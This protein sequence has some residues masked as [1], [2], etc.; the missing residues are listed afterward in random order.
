MGTET[1]D[2]KSM[3]VLLVD[4]TPANLDVLRKTLEQKDLKVSVATNGEMALKIASKLLP[5][6]I[7]LDIMMPGIDGFETCR[8]LKSKDSTKEIPVIF[9]SA[10]NGPEDF[11]QGFIVGG[12]DYITK[13]FKQEE[14]FARVE[15]HL[16]LQF[17]KKELEK[18]KLMVI[19]K[20]NRLQNQW[21][22]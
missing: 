9:I 16:E 7:L 1:F 2:L 13:P 10:K 22:T 20:N 5:D 19:K 15:T 21:K 18:A 11:V 4:D 14:V 8:I 6:L 3:K 17:L 12:A